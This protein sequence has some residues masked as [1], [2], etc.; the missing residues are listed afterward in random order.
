MVVPDLAFVPVQPGATVTGIGFHDVDY[1]HEP[2]DGTDWTATVTS[3]S[4]TWA[5][6]TF[7]TNPNANALR[8]GTLYNFRFDAD[9][10]P[11]T[12]NAT[13]NLFKS[14][15]QNFTL[16]STVVPVSCGL[17]PNGTFCNDFNPCTQ[18]DR[19][20]ANVCTGTQPVQCTAIDQCHTAGTCNLSTGRC[21]TPSKPD[22]TACDDA[23]ACT[24]GEACSAGVCTGTGPSLPQDVGDT[25]TLERAEGG[26]T[27]SWTA[28]GGSDT[29]SVLRG[30][31]SGLPVGPGGGDELCLAS[32][33]A[34]T[35]VIDAEDPEAGVGFWYV[36]RGVS[37]CG[38][39]PYG[40]ARQSA[41]CP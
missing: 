3:S 22:G 19:C 34:G 7:A 16:V 4:I 36:V 24:E 23:N 13:I 11:G 28:A 26:T 14:G 15:L 38:A 25:V 33:I 2:F 30:A 39:G 20:L 18:V 5:T 29:S 37:A 8:W 12:A 40:D 21:S 35:S 32:G 6:Q 1:D 41:T 10:A 27:I 31:L 9:V 17:A